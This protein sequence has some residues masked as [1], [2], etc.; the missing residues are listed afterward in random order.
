MVETKKRTPTG[1]NTKKY[2]CK[3][4]EVKTYEYQWKKYYKYDKKPKETWNQRGG[5]KKLPK[6]LVMD[7]IKLIDTKHYDEILKYLDKFLEKK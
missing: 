1:I 2:V 3:N 5:R 6:T 7:K 4:G